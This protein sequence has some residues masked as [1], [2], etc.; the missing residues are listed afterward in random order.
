MI[1]FDIEIQ[2]KLSF[3]LEHIFYADIDFEDKTYRFKNDVNDHDKTLCKKW[4]SKIFSK[5]K[6]RQIKMINKLYQ[7]TKR[8]VDMIQNFDHNTKKRFEFLLQSKFNTF[9]LN[10]SLRWFFKDKDKIYRISCIRWIN[11]ITL[12]DEFKKIIH[13]SYVEERIKHAF[14]NQTKADA[15]FIHWSKYETWSVDEFLALMF[16][17]DPRIVCFKNVNEFVEGLQ[18]QEE[19]IYSFIVAYINLFKIAMRRFRTPPYENGTIWLSVKKSRE[20]FLDWAIQIQYFPPKELQEL[21]E[22]Q[23]NR[24]LFNYSDYEFLKKKYEEIK[25]ERDQIKKRVEELESIQFPRLNK[26]NK[27]YSEELAIAIEAYLAVIKEPSDTKSPKQKILKFLNAKY[28]LLP[29]KA[30]NRIATVC[31]WKPE[32]GATSTPVS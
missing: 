11:E 7:I 3:L 24:K 8:M 25:S 23:I 20:E 9:Q 18:E 5:E 32:G 31:N 22:E 15:D 21:V 4:M 6:E 14:F 16:K 28:P 30:K 2:E 17:K 12:N 27:F 1:E 29:E 13:N 19:K 26:D 10:D